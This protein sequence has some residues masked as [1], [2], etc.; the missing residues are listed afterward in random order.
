MDPKEAPMSR[1][2]LLSDLHLSDT[3]G[4]FWSNW[5]VARD[6]ANA[7]A[8]DLVVICGDLCIDG[9]D[10]PNETALA[11]R[12]VQ[13]LAAPFRALPGNHDVGEEPPGQAPDQITTPERLARWN[14]VFGSDRFAET[15]G[16]W[17][18]IGLNAQ[19]LGCGLPEEA[20]QNAWLD[21]ELA[22]AKGP[23]ALILHKPLF[24]ADEGEPEFTATCT[25]P[26]ARAEL[27]AR[28]R[29]ADVRIVISGHLHAYRD[30]V[31]NN[32]RYLWLPATSFIGQSHAGADPIVGL[33]SIELEN[34]TPEVTLHR[35]EGLVAHDLVKIKQGRYKFLREM[36][37]CPPDEAA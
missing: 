30:I 35:P 13:R 24:L 28:L 31:I 15:V 6:A 3:H 7:L 36:P 2:V 32:I 11:G 26:V 8:G 12:A 33:V 18:V 20:G 22:T 29:K 25:T 19:L 14:A 17:R 10:K 4:F 34:E 37:A 1:L 9:T 16:A 23:I 21:A 5:C 27:L